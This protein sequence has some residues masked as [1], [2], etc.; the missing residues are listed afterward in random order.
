MQDAI[1]TYHQH[2]ITWKQFFIE[3]LHPNE[4][5]RKSIFNVIQLNEWKWEIV[6]WCCV[7][8]TNK[9]SFT[10]A[11][12]WGW[13]FRRHF[14]RSMNSTLDIR[15]YK[16]NKNY[17]LSFLFKHP[18]KKNIQKEY[19][20]MTRKEYLLRKWRPIYFICIIRDNNHEISVE[21]QIKWNRFFF[22]NLIRKDCKINRTM[23]RMFCA[24][25]FPSF[26]ILQL[27]TSVDMFVHTIE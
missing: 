22:G 2:Q 10:L 16:V 17:L 14:T 27:T 9:N 7:Y 15:R 21:L 24:D 20:F 12:H 18:Y 5:N 11:Q 1:K 25:F 6:S 8:K 3:I 4:F 19:N 13:I 26:W 23:P